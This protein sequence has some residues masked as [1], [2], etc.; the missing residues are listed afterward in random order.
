MYNENLDHH[1]EDYVDLEG[2]YN[3]MD[4]NDYAF[5]NAIKNLEN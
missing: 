2:C 3:G 4:S 1:S 5:E